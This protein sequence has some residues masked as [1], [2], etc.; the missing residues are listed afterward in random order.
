[1]DE[2][3]QGTDSPNVVRFPVIRIPA[4]TDKTTPPT[5]LKFD[6]PISGPMWA[7][8]A[9]YTGSYEDTFDYTVYDRLHHKF[10]TS[11]PRGGIL[12]KTTFR[13]VNAHSSCRHCHYAFEIDTYG[14]GCTFN[15]TYCYAKE[16]LSSHKMWNEP[17]PFPIDISLVRKEFYKAFE[18]D[19]MSR[20]ARILRQRVPLR[21]GSMSDSFMWVD[22]KYGVTKELL[23]ILNHYQYPHVIFTRSDLVAEDEYLELLNPTLATVQMSLSGLNEELT[24]ALE[25]GAPSPERRLRAL[26]VLADRGIWTAVRLNPLLPKYPDG[27]FSDRE[28]VIRRFGTK[29]SIPQ[30]D[31]LD[32]DNIGHFASQVSEAGVKTLL[33]GFG[34]LSINAIYNIRKC[35]GTDLSLFFRPELLS[36]ADD[37]KYADSE[38]AHYYK[39]IQWAALK[40]Q[41]R[42]TTCYIGNGDKDYYQYQTLW[43]N[44]SDCCDVIG[45]IA[46]FKTTCQS[47]PE[48]DRAGYLSQKISPTRRKLQPP[49]NVD[50]VT[51][52]ELSL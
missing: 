9:Q 16:Q 21:I 4:S 5:T 2:Q 8:A 38:I 23:R 17:H 18:T 45:N 44:R 33:V 39:R 26:R 30:F 20:W 31:I 11:P 13:L 40:Y 14:R 6:G 32:I 12:F 19:K 49:T 24:R 3:I 28:S 42:F 51:N 52:P 50:K 29:S 35:T 48:A 43:A 1:M 27:Y 15:C 25:P 10:R 41:L 47:I 7:S 37:R 34:R 22:K 46:S 36:K